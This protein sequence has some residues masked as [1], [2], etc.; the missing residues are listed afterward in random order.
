MSIAGIKVVSPSELKERSVRRYERDIEH[1][2]K[3][4][5]DEWNHNPGA[6]FVYKVRYRLYHTDDWQYYETR[7]EV[8]RHAVGFIEAKLR[9]VGWH[10][11][12][13][14]LDTSLFG[15][16]RISVMRSP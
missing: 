9:L 12:Y 16:W 6:P 4:F 13:V 8:L 7:E 15:V 5:F 3:R 10:D 14:V 2:V 11:T 1:V